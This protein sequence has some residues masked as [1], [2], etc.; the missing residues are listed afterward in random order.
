MA[1]TF[2]ILPHQHDKREEEVIRHLPGQ[3][4]ISNVSAAMKQLGDPTRLRIFWL[5]C[6]IEECVTNIADIVDMTSPAVSHHLR[7]LKN[8]G[9]ITSR[10]K[11][12]EMYYRAADTALA[13]ALHLMIEEVGRITCPTDS[14]K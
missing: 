14:D 2:R 9:L 1:E 5:L 8:A 10:R 6:H 3:D 12:R 7:L 4:T 13:N 11:G